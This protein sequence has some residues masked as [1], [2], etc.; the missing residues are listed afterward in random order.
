MRKMNQMFTKILNNTRNHIKMEWNE[1]KLVIWCVSQRTD[2]L[3]WHHNHHHVCGNNIKQTHKDKNNNTKTIERVMHIFIAAKR[4]NWSFSH[5]ETKNWLNPSTF[6]HQHVQQ[7][8]S[9][10]YKFEIA[11]HIMI[12]LTFHFWASVKIN[13]SALQ[14]QI[15]QYTQFQF[16]FYRTIIYLSRFLC[17]FASRFGSRFFDKL[18]R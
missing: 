6:M 10:S 18:N 17:Y 12:C 8:F 15:V 13:P 9:Y 2:C 5:H 14:P 16:Q 7:R 11:F 3:K 1:M 4:S